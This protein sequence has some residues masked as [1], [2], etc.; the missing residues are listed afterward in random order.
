VFI[1]AG[2]ALVLYPFATPLFEDVVGKNMP[3]LASFPAAA[4]FVLFLFISLTGISAGLYP[5]F[6]LSSLEFNRFVKRQTANGKGKDMAAQSN[7][8]FSVLHCRSGD[9]GRL[10]CCAAGFLFL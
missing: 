6:V 3:P 5:A 2:A 1:A 7:G 8:W 9:G 4:V 10:Y